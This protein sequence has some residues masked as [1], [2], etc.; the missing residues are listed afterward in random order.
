MKIFRRNR[1]EVAEKA[2]HV[3]A[4]QFAGARK[5]PRRVRHVR[6]A[7]FMDINGEPRIFADKRTRSAGVVQMNMRKQNGGEIVD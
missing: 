5:E 3:R 7:E 6:S 1:K 2:L 4:I